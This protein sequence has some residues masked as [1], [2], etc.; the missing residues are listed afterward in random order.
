M[1][2]NKGILSCIGSALFL[3]LH[4]F[5]WLLLCWQVAKPLTTEDDLLA[6]SLVCDELGAENAFRG[7]EQGCCKDLVRSVG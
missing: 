6:R 1:Q 4:F 2:S 5:L 7:R 3:F